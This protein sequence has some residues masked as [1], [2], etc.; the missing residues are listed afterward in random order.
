VRE[1]DGGFY[2]RSEMGFCP[3]RLVFGKRPTAA[4]HDSVVCVGLRIRL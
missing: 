4:N 2:T 3:L 1:R